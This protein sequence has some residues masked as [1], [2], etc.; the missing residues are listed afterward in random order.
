MRRQRLYSLD[1]W[2]IFLLSLGCFAYLIFTEVFPTDFFLSS[3]SFK[4]NP[5]FVFQKNSSHKMLCLKSFYQNDFNKYLQDP[6]L[7][8]ENTSY[9]FTSCYKDKKIALV[10]IEGT[11]F[12]AH[13]FTPKSIWT[14]FTRIPFQASEAF[15][16]WYY[17]HLLS[18]LNINATKPLLI[19][20]KQTGP[21]CFTS[22]LITSY[23]SGINGDE[24]F[25]KSSAFKE[26]WPETSANILKTINDLSLSK[27]VQN[28]FCLHN[29]IIKDNQPH[30]I[31]LD[32]LHSYPLSH[33]LHQKRHFNKY[34]S[35]LENNLEFSSIEAYNI[36]KNQALV[37][38][39]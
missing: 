35:S 9:Y 26:H 16:A 17:G 6:E 14:Y 19:I 32:K 15:R 37:S 27:I 13:K 31:D 39:L 3:N 8:F 29:F 1:F 28:N 21:F 18:K 25:K 2:T 7:L 10:S 23:V 12:I 5:D 30:L 38:R 33:R 24:Y 11:Y 34:F 4:K 22:Y 36:F 20:E